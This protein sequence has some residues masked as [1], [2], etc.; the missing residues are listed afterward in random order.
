M[1]VYKVFG[2]GVF[3]RVVLA[4]SLVEA[5]MLFLRKYPEQTIRSIEIYSDE[6]IIG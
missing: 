4:P 1:K 5:G 2:T 3:M 6:V